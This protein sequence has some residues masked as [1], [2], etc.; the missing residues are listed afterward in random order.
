M[1]II[2]PTLHNYYYTTKSHRGIIYESALC[3][4]RLNLNQNKSCSPLH[5]LKE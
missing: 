1:L 2:L 3:V 4:L 5:L